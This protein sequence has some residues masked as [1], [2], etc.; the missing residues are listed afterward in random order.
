MFLFRN[1]VIGITLCSIAV[2]MLIILV[3]PSGILG[4]VLAVVLFFIGLYLI[5][6][7]KRRC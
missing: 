2:G 4:L 7:K 6:N 1:K 5:K 3:L